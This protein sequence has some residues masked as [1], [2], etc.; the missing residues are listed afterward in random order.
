MTDSADHLA[1]D[2]ARVF[3]KHILIEGMGRIR[4]CVQR[5]DE[6]QV[7]MRP[8]QAS[9]AIGNLL[10]HLEGNV[11]QWVLVGLGG[12]ESPRDRPAEFAAREGGTSKDELVDALAATV[13]QAV[14]IV[15]ATTPA[16]LLATY[17]FQD[18]KFPD[19]GLGCVL[20]VMEHF[21]GHAYQIFDRTKQLIGQDLRFYDL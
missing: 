8:N 18:G 14:A 7:W 13:Q 19:T 10:L 17:P 11:R 1:R 20:H 2:V 4:A 12:R 5:L 9:N 15:E 16:S 3:R 21:S 6:A